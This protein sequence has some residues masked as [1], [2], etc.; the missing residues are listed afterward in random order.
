MLAVQPAVRLCAGVT[1]GGRLLVREP[2]RAEMGLPRQRRAGVY[3]GLNWVRSVTASEL[4]S[5]GESWV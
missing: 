3:T 4:G 2:R 5:L 1:V